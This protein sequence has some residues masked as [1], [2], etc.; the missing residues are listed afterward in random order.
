MFSEPLNNTCCL[1]IWIICILLLSAC[2][3][4]GETEK[5]EN[6]ESSHPTT[7]SMPPPLPTRSGSQPPPLPVRPAS[8]PSL[9]TNTGPPPLPQGSSVTRPDSPRSL[10]LRRVEVIDRQ[11]FARPLKAVEMLIPADWLARGEVV[12]QPMNSCQAEVRQFQWQAMTADGATGFEFL[13]GRMWESTNMAMNQPANCAR[14]SERSLRPYLEQLT[15]ARRPNARVLGYE[16][17]SPKLREFSA[18]LQQ[19]ALQVPGL[20]DRRWAEGG[21]LQLSWIENGREMREIL[22]A[23]GVFSELTWSSGERYLAGAVP[24]PLIMAYRAPA[25]QFDPGMLAF[26]QESW[27]IGPEWE[28]EIA[29]LEAR[30]ANE[31]IEEG[32]KRHAIN[33]DTINHLG[34]LSRSGYEQR[35]GAQERGSHQF[36]QTIRGVQTWTDPARDG[37]SFEL[38]TGY[39]NAWR[40]DDDSFIL[41]DNPDFHPW[42]DMRLRGQPL[43]RGSR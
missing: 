43:Q 18:L 7:V 10:H 4:E 1:P 12:W 20:M 17:L 39:A 11:G 2:Q 41:T 29:Q 28:R 34:N 14:G 13:P 33:M 32:K 26:I 23:I 40:L 5:A 8:D 22:F 38:P 27:R 3:G 15:R 36:S 16:D 6:S 24:A 35:I 37:E 19:T 9:S 42:S 21:R 31:A 30:I 25:E